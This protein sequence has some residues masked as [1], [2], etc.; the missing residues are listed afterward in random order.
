MKA[1]FH[2]ALKQHGYD[3]TAEDLYLKLACELQLLKGI[4]GLTI[5]GGEPMLQIHEVKKLLN[6]CKEHGIH[7]AVETSACVPKQF[8]Q[9][10]EE[11]VDCWLFGLKQTA[12]ALCKK[13]T[14]ADFDVILENFRYLSEKCPEKII[15]RTPLIEP[16]TSNDAN[17]QTICSLM[18]EYGI[19]KIQLL[20]Y[21][22]YTSLYYHSLGVPFHEQSYRAVSSE[23]LKKI[24]N[25]FESS[26]ISCTYLT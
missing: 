13:M 2:A 7:T 19:T 10:L 26:H 18:G 15:V 5:S 21:N 11:N 17:M 25:M 16:V 23:A 22:P 3:L 8:F 14:G 12:P 9:E 1:C 6:L 4:G 20:K 24:I